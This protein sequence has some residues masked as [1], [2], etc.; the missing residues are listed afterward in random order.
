M[1]Y[2]V[3]GV[4][5]S[6][7]QGKTIQEESPVGICQSNGV[8][9]RAVQEIEGRIRAIYLGLQDRVGSNIYARVGLL[10]LFLFM[11]RIC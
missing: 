6:R 11:P 1:K 2:V 4:I 10:H 3:Q 8:V 9:E 7:E 5:D